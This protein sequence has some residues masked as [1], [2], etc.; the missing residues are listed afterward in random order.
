MKIKANIYNSDTKKYE[1]G[2]IDIDM[3]EEIPQEPIETQ[4]PDRLT[5]LELAVAELGRMVLGGA[6]ND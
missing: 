2:Y 4:E 3:T 6:A 5:Q 1:I